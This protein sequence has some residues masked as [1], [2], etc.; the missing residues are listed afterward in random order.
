MRRAAR[1]R[2]TTLP[3]IQITADITPAIYFFGLLERKRIELLSFRLYPR[4]TY[5]QG[6]TIYDIR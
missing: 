5:P 4:F 6:G 3:L 1:L 2:N